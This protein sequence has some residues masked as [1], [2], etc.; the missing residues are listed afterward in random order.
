MVGSDLVYESGNP[1]TVGE[2]GEHEYVF[3]RGN[4][5]A[6][7]GVSTLVFES[8]T[9]I[10][11]DDLPD[12]LPTE[13]IAR[14]D[15]A[16]DGTLAAEWVAE[17]LAVPDEDD[18]RTGV[19]ADGEGVFTSHV[20]DEDGHVYEQADGDVKWTFT[21]D[22]SVES[23][24]SKGGDSGAIVITAGVVDEGAILEG[25]DS[26]DGGL[27]WSTVVD[28]N[29]GGPHGPWC[30]VGDGRAVYAENDVVE[31]VECDTGNELWT[32]SPSGRPGYVYYDGKNLHTFEVADGDSMLSGIDPVDGSVLWTTELQLEDGE[33][34][35]QH[36]TINGY[37]VYHQTDYALYRFDG[38]TGDRLWRVPTRDNTDSGR[39][40]D[41][42]YPPAHF[43]TNSNAVYFVGEG[44]LGTDS[45]TRFILCR[46]GDSAGELNEAYGF[47]SSLGLHTVRNAG[48]AVF[49]SDDQVF[50][51]VHG[52]GLGFIKAFDGATLEPLWDAY[53]A[54]DGML[55]FHRGSFY[56]SFHTYGSFWPD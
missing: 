19:Y 41:I 53:V 51:L 6:D 5:L 42:Y 55:Q 7:R 21:L 40:V 15:I 47:D 34:D 28:Y 27:Q 4:P 45:T 56:G 20:F 8:G 32:V 50:V 37:R 24:N 46:V 39:E 29:L 49:A 11:G 43:G 33:E 38:E 26:G 9:G 17:P 18:S 44:T 13:V 48:S 2:H 14:I 52:D 23:T 3:V 1:V 31:A 54:S 12:D 30:T 36:T 10:G 22:S 25:R 35:H 16:T